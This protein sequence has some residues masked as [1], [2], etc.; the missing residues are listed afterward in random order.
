MALKRDPRLIRRLTGPGGLQRLVQALRTQALV[1]GDSRIAST[2]ARKATTR[3]LPANHDLITQGADDNDLYFILS[4]AI[5]IE[6]NGR[7]IATRTAHEHVG[8]IALLDTMALRSAT[9]KTKEPTVVAMISERDFTKIAASYRSS[10]EQ[11]L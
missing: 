9:A 7:E 6:V 1:G 4:G 8:E 10:G 3:Q 2:L 5:A 11:W